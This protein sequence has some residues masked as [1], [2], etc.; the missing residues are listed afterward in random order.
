MAAA[1]WI[2]AAAGGRPFTGRVWTARE[3]WI[4]FLP[5]LLPAYISIGQ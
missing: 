2:P 3:D 1:G 5:G 4:V